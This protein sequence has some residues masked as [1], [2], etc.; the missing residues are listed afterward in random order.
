MKK[1]LFILF[2]ICLFSCQKKELNP[3]IGNWYFDQIVDYD[4]SKIKFPKIIL[5]TEFAPYYNFEILNDS[6]L[7]YKQGFYYTIT[8]K[9]WNGNERHHFLRSHYFLGSK[10]KYK[11]DKSNILFFDKTSKSFDTIKIKKIW[12]D[13]MIVQGYEN[14][15]YRLVKKQNNYFDDKSYDA[16]TVDRSPC[17]GSC[18]FN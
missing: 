15:F 18:P 9:V 1:V 5:E 16:I 3:Y 11:I 4:S 7:D 8:N 2:F 13:T 14:A 6:V 12:N 17:F 10:T